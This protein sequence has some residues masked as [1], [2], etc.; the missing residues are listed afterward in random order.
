MR[1][2][3]DAALIRGYKSCSQQARVMTED[4]FLNE[5]YCPSCGG[6]VSRY[7]ANKPVADFFC[8]KCRYDF[9]LKSKKDKTSNRIVDGAYSTM[10]Q[11]LESDANPHLFFMSYRGTGVN[12]LML[13]PKHFFTGDII[14]KRKPLSATARRAG[15][16][17]CN[18]LL[19]MIP[20][21][22]K[23]FYVRDGK[24]KNKANILRTYQKTAFLKSEKR[25]IKGWLLDVMR[26]VDKLDKKVFCLDDVYMFE[27][28]LSGLH[29][30]NKNIRPKIRQQLQLLRDR[31]YLRFEGKGRYE[32][33]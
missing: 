8:G 12:N 25:D 15:W 24:V 27:K 11:R 3:M 21:S 31:G 14:E 13:I 26:C 7:E 4:W 29:P 18:I 33:V 19:D 17:G 20:E 28:Y 22:G 9:E 23:I 10:I 2:N 5:S 6:G 1:L 16:T 32:L 30:D